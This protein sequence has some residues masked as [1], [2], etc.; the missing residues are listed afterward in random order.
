M[1]AKTAFVRASG[2]LELKF[3]LYCSDRCEAGQ[4]GRCGFE[5]EV[6]FDQ[7]A[8]YRTEGLQ[9]QFE[10]TAHPQSSAKAEQSVRVYRFGYKR[11]PMSHSRNVKVEDEK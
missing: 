11:Q 2:R 1:H 8:H 5:S 6:I 9:S 10:P 3:M 4:P 7:V